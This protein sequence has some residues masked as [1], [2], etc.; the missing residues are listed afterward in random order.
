MAQ[1]ARNLG[2]QEAF[3][4]T[5]PHPARRRR[6]DSRR[7]ELLRRLSRLHFANASSRPRLRSAWGP[8]R[9]FLDLGLLLQHCLDDDVQ[10]VG[11]LLAVAAAIPADRILVETDVPHL[12]PEPYRGKRPN[13]PARVVHTAACLA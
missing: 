13:E 2:P 8:P 7:G 12:S 5:T 9:E 1:V 10:E 11:Q 3:L 4:R 6:A